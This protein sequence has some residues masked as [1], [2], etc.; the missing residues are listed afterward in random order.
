MSNNN[1]L[2]I[3]LSKR[4]IRISA[5]SNEKFSD[6]EIQVKLVLAYYWN[7]NFP[8][9]ENL[10]ELIEKVIKNSISKVFPHNILKLKYQ[11]VSDDNIKK[12]S[13]ISIEFLEIKADEID[14][15]ILGDLIIL[16]TSNAKSSLSKLKK[17]RRKKKKIIEKEI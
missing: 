15:E 10:L 9:V 5:K 16:K 14:F 4:T 7:E 17:F 12:A 3:E 6:H 8:V 1:A 2:T 13:S 11:V